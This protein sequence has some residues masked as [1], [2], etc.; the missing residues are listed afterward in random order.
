MGE[1]RHGSFNR[2]CNDGF[3]SHASEGFGPPLRTDTCCM[4]K[5]AANCFRGLWEGVE[6]LQ[7]VNP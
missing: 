4:Q 5:Q 3:N 1:I 7:Y 6:L 2:H